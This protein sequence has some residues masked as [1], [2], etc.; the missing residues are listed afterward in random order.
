MDAR[1][2]VLE[3]VRVIRKTFPGKTGIG[4][5]T[6][7]GLSYIPDGFNEICRFDYAQ[8]PGFPVSTVEGHKGELVIGSLHG[9]TVLVMM[10][11]FHLYEGYSPQQVT[12]P[13]RVMQEMGIDTLI[14]NNAAGGINPGF[15]PGDIMIITDHVNLTGANPLAGPNIDEWGIRFPDMSRAYDPELIQTVHRAASKNNVTVVEG[16]YA[17][18]RGPSLETPAEIRFLRTIGCDAV[19]LS[20]VMEVI[21]GVHADI[22]ILGLSLITNSHDPDNPAR[23]TLEEV[24]ETAA[25]SIPVLN[26]LICEIIHLLPRKADK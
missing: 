20:T 1:Q 22:N 13:I 17:G 2:N 5:L 21:A 23:T 18:L 26:G 7:T 12:F 8:L 19:G 15:S 3:S 25:Q 24:L 10:G 16:V 14:V 9:Q 4:L 11:R 6:G